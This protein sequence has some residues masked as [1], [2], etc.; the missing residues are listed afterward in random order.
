MK[1]LK[2]LMIAPLAA[3]IAMPVYAHPHHSDFETY[4][5]L[6]DR[7]ERQK[8]RIK[9]GVKSGAL[10]KKEASKLRKQQRKLANLE[11]KFTSDGVLSRSERK[12]L[13]KKRDKA[14]DRIYRLKHN[15]EVRVH[16]KKHAINKHHRHSVLSEKPHFSY[17]DKEYGHYGF[18]NRHN[19]DSLSLILRFIDF[20]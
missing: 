7:A 1:L 13:K 4:P 20:Y 8:M 18:E 9:N 15:D 16:G 12:K 11:E 14:S 6:G 19:N 17:R 10:T 2:V 3:L 5:I